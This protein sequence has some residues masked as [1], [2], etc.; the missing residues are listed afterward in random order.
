MAGALRSLRNFSSLVRSYPS[1]VMKELPCTPAPLAS[2]VPARSSE[3]S[4]LRTKEMGSWKELTVE[5]KVTLYNASFNTTFAGMRA[6]TGEWKS[7]FGGVGVGIGVAMIF[8][9][10][11][12]EYVAPPK[13]HTITPEW[14]AATRDKLLKQKAN[15]IEGIGSRHRSGA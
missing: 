1:G 10:V 14:E 8:F 5:E 9:Y 4:A 2:T 7:V 13:P 3:L 11:L 12:R 15:P 6:P